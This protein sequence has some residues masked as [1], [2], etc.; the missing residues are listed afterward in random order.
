[1]SNNGVLNPWFLTGFVD[2]EGCFQVSI[3][4]DLKQKI[5]WRVSSA[6]QIKLHIKDLALLE[7]IKNTLGVGTI[8]T[9]GKNFCNYNVWSVKELQVLIYHFD[10]YS[11]VTDKVSDYL[12]F[13]QCFQIIKN[14]EHLTEKG[15][16]QILSLKSSLNLG[17]SNQLKEAFPNVMPVNRPLHNSNCIPDPYWVSGFTSGDGSFYFHLRELNSTVSSNVYR[18]VVLN[19]V[20]CLHSRDAKVLKNLETYFKAYHSGTVHRELKVLVLNLY[21]KTRRNS[22]PRNEPLHL[23]NTENTVTLYF[24]KFSD[25]VNIIIPFF[26][27]YPILGV[28]RLDF[29]NFKKVAE[30]VKTKRH[31]TSEGYKK[32][33]EIDSTMNLRRPWS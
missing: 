22:S 33:V 21:L 13:K 31:L 6:F 27:Q 17:L 7:Q 29:E 1:M 3:R 4:Q 8:T 18:K 30:I 9:D 28:K 25:I 20:I 5:K 23:Y 14:R 19:F 16:L 26:D 24:R 11:L 12:L 15:L 32:I 2:A 10:I